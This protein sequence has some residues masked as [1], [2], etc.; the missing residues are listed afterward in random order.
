MSEIKD[1]VDEY[2]AITSKIHD[3]PEIFIE[4]EA[5]MI[6]SAT[7]GRYAS[8]VVSYKPWPIKPNLWA[9]F[10]GPSRIVRKSTA[11][12]F[13]VD[14]IKTIDEY[15]EY[16]SDGSPEGI[17]TKMKDLKK[18]DAIGFMRDELGGFFKSLQKKYMAGTREIFNFA[19]AGREY[20]RTLR[21]GEVRIPQGLYFIVLGTIPTPLSKYKCFS[22]EDFTS[23][24][25]NRFLLVY[26]EE[27][28]RRYPITHYDAEA[29]KQRKQLLEKF[30]DEYQKVLVN[31][32]PPS[33]IVSFS[34]EVNNLLDEFDKEIDK[35]VKTERGSFFSNY[36]A[37]QGQNLMKLMVLHRLGRGRLNSPVLLVERVDY[38]HALRYLREVLNGAEKLIKEDF[39]RKEDEPPTLPIEKVLNYIKDSQ[40]KGVSWG[41]LR[42]KFPWDKRKLLDTVELLY[43]QGKI[44]AYRVKTKGRPGVYFVAKEY[45]NMVTDLRLVKID[46]ATVRAILK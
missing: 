22:E 37:E 8:L 36:I 1:F 20:V 44:I 7:L 3:A 40:E 18:G 15:F 30:R 5:Y 39:E 28:E 9:I 31:M 4:T 42:Q 17:A 33:F 11:F 46:F 13:T 14:G 10:L 35:I 32:Q 26:A 41:R 45:R 34:S 38:E 19:H 6:L 27:R 2:V 25:L 16:F 23:G 12:D 24:F 29:T 21:N 43:D